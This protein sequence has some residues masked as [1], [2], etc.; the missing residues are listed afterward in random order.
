MVVDRSDSR[1]TLLLAAE[2][3]AQHF[4]GDLE[5]LASIVKDG[6]PTEGQLLALAT[7]WRQTPEAQEHFTLASQLRLSRDVRVRLDLLL[8]HP[9]A[10]LQAL[11]SWLPEGEGQSWL[12]A[13]PT[14]A[15]LRRTAGDPRFAGAL[16]RRI[17]DG[18][19]PSE[20]GSGARL[21][22]AAGRLDSETRAVLEK[23]CAAALT[24][25][26]IDLIGLDMVAEELRPLG[27]ILWDALH[28]GT[29]TDAG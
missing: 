23:R 1:T 25:P 3:L 9:D 12:V 15:A 26:D 4:A 2:L 21:L 14:T 8:A 22:A 16:M 11:C 18:G 5:V 20:V 24:G 10:A 28:G 29:A 19:T 7:G 17:Q 6:H 27:W 13:P